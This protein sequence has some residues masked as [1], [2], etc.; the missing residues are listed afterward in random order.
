MLI[1]WDN[2][3]T[4][5]LPSYIELLSYID[6][7]CHG[8]YNSTDYDTGA[9]IDTGI[10][11]TTNTKIQTL[12]QIDASRS[13]YYG[14]YFGCDV[15]TDTMCIVSRVN[16]SNNTSLHGAFLQHKSS[17]TTDFDNENKFVTYQLFLNNLI[18]NGKTFQ[19]T[20]FPVT[21]SISTSSLK[22]G[23]G[24]MQGRNYRCSRV[25]VKYFKIVDDNQVL[26]DGIAA[27]DNR[28]GLCGLWD[29]V[30]RQL[31]TSCVVGHEFIGVK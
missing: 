3:N 5:N 4:N 19:L 16:N 18:V 27:K 6:S 25:L 8:T 23:C 17:W 14:A 24:N 7:D 29:S 1:G 2:R 15:D 13:Q 10:K 11:I 31:K 21:S 12:M 30:S 9:A 22:I 20:Q 26:F 28:S